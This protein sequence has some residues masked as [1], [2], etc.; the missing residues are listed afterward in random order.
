MEAAINSPETDMDF[1]V[2]TIR[3]L[4]VNQL[5]LVLSHPLRSVFGIYDI[6]SSSKGLLN[7]RISIQQELGVSLDEIDKAKEMAMEIIKERKPFYLK[8]KIKAP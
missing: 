7:E 4:N 6:L 2:F 3:K 1:Y 5:A 8:K